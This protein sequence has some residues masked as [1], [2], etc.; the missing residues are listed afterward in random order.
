MVPPPAG[1]LRRTWPQRLLILFNL[2]VIAACIAAAVLVRGAEQQIRDIPR[3]SFESDVLV[4]AVEPGEP[5]TFLLVGAD[6]SAGLDEGD[7]RTVGRNL[8]QEAAG[9]IR[10]DSIVLL[11]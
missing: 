8:S 9:Q 11:R 5:L 3:V 2:V 10:A 1:R 7:P 4:D 6:S